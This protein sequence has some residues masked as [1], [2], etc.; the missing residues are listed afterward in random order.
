MGRIEVLALKLDLLCLRPLHL[1]ATPYHKAEAGQELPAQ[2]FC[3][4]F[5]EA[6]VDSTPGLEAE[7]PCPGQRECAASVKLFQT[8]P[9]FGRELTPSKVART[10]ET[11]VSLWG[12]CS[13][14]PLYDSYRPR[15]E[16]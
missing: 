11:V 3:A 5:S 9:R 6:A 8:Y 4:L 13:S 7:T 10:S 15:F 2:M 12:G 1:T 16:T 14:S